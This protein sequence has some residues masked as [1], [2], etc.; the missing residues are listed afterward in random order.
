MILSHAE[1]KTHNH[2]IG[3]KT[4]TTDK[5]KRSQEQKSS[6]GVENTE[7]VLFDILRRD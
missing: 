4:D 5:N 2:A 7:K 1:S 6:S 3:P